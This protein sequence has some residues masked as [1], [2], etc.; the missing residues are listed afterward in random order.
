MYPKYTVLVIN[1]TFKWIQKL[2]NNGDTFPVVTL[3]YRIR[4]RQT[5]ILFIFHGRNLLT[6]MNSYLFRCFRSLLP[7]ILNKERN[8]KRNFLLT[9]SIPFVL[10][11]EVS[12]GTGLGTFD[13]C[14]LECTVFSYTST[15][16]QFLELNPFSRTPETHPG[17]LR[18]FHFLS[19]SS[20]SQFLLLASPVWLHWRPKLLSSRG[21][22][23]LTSVDDLRSFPF[24]Y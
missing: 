12:T 23:F 15:L 19:S 22:R 20:Q 24:F 3:L 14:T 8:T 7:H 1:K 21:L 10:L 9:S 4:F 17:V 6:F 16:M 11:Q 13:T 18:N 2:R 5:F